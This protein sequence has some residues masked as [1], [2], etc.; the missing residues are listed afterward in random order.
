MYYFIQI[1]NLK[2]YPNKKHQWTNEVKQSMLTDTEKRLLVTRRERAS[3]VG[4]IGEDGQLYGDKW[5]QDLW[6]CSQCSVY[7]CQTIMLYTWNVHICVSVYLWLID[8]ISKNN[9]NSIGKKRRGS[10]YR[11]R[12][13]Q[14]QRHRGWDQKSKA[15]SR[16]FQHFIC[17]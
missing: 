16:K 7:R 4:K 9:M 14:V 3:G 11:Q 8:W 15:Y 12:K 10:R 5:Q 2:R 1:W 13:V 6:W 17:L